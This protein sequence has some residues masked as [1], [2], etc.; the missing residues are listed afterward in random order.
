[1]ASEAT[2]R[3]VFVKTVRDVWRIGVARSAST[4]L[5]NDVASQLIRYA[6]LLSCSLSIIIAPRNSSLMWQHEANAVSY[7][8][9][10]A[11]MHARILLRLFIRYYAARQKL[12]HC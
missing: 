10:L 6:S 9:F 12:C 5:Q 8:Y 2:A 3:N 7:V 11:Y 1:M 4:V